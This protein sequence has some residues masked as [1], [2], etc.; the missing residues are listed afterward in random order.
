MEGGR[1]AEFI[2]DFIDSREM[3]CAHHELANRFRPDARLEA[4]RG[5]PKI[6]VQLHVEEPTAMA[7]S[8]T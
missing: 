5:A 8:A 2:P 1:L 7:T 6:V 4:A 3:R